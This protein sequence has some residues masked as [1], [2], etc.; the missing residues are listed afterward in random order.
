M[1]REELINFGEMFLEVNVDSPNSNTYQF[2]S[3][4][5]KL[6]KHENCED[7]VSRQSVKNRMIKYGFYAQD[8]TVTEFVED[9]LQPVITHKKEDCEMSAE[10]YR[11]RM[12]Q[13]F[14]NAGADELIAVCVPPAE[15]EFKLLEGMLK[16]RYNKEH[17]D[18]L[19]SKQ[20]EGE[21]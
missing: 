3:A 18:D 6:L 21:E 10:E 13:A 19:V 4:A 17:S 16:D 5:L 2:V 15:E 8:M 14:H 7:A 9:V 20:Q 11:Q 12:I 1:T